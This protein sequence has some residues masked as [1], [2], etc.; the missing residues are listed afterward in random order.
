MATALVFLVDLSEH[1]CSG[2]PLT[3][4]YLHYLQH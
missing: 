1:F 4:L 3:I 2:H